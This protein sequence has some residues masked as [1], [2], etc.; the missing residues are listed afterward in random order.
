LYWEA[1]VSSQLRLTSK[2]QSFISTTIMNFRMVNA[3][4]LD[5]IASIRVPRNGRRPLRFPP[6]R[7]DHSRDVGEAGSTCLMRAAIGD[8]VQAPGDKELVLNL[9]EECKAISDANGYPSRAA[10]S[11]RARGM[12]TEER[13]LLTASML[14]DIE[15]INNAPI[16]ADH[17]V[18]D[19]IRRG[20]EP[21]TNDIRELEV[22]RSSKKADAIRGMKPISRSQRLGCACSPPLR[23][24][25]VAI[26][27]ACA[28]VMTPS[29]GRLLDLRLFGLISS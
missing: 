28:V 10:F 2:G 8:I 13:S 20:T 22:L 24:H 21:G 5:R 11:E 14:R 4:E 27:I 15:R 17:I 12:L 19:L 26:I 29:C 6:E 9:F 18:G 16:E 23:R 7:R 1:N 3:T 25:T